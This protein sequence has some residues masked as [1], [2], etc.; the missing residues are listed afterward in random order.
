MDCA[1]SAL[2]PTPVNHI[3]PRAKRVK[4]FMRIFERFLRTGENVLFFPA[5]DWWRSGAQFLSF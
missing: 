3:A 4:L 1:H 5:Y 2:I